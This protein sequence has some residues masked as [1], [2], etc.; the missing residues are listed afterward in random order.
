MQAE[1]EAII[2]AAREA[3]R[4]VPAIVEELILI[5]AKKMDGAAPAPAV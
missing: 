5:I 3:G 1:I 4:D 2:A